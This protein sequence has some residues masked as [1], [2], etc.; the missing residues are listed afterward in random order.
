M[1]TARIVNEANNQEIHFAP[2]FLFGSQQSPS[3]RSFTS[4]SRHILPGYNSPGIL[5]TRDLTSS[6]NKNVHWSPV[7]VRERSPSKLADEKIK[8]TGSDINK[9]STL[10]S[11]GPPLRSLNDIIVVPPEKHPRLEPSERLNGTKKTV[12]LNHYEIQDNLLARTEL[13][14]LE[15]E[16]GEDDEIY[17]VTVFGFQSEQN[18][19]IL[20]LF[21]R[22]GDIMAQKIPKYGNW[23]HIRYSSPV[24]ARQALSKNAS[25]FK[26]LMIGVIPCKDRDALE[27]ESGQRTK[28]LFP[29][30]NSNQISD[31]SNKSSIL[32]G[33]K[34]LG[35]DDSSL[36]DGN[37]LVPS[38][39]ANKSN[40]SSLPSRARLSISSRAGMRPLNSSY[41][42]KDGDNNMDSS[43]QLLN[44]SGAGGDD[45]FMGK[46]WNIFT[47][48]GTGS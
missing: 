14:Q 24:H 28:P 38:T 30:S 12:P 26:G 10:L 36:F 15:E 19:E 1:D 17:W 20:E 45:S 43:F 25:I 47:T 21:S 33:S 44:R 9:S 39:S 48:T 29:Q 37:R 3:R 34:L 4:P 16:N 6:G 40:R 23:I 18:G 22:H 35:Q 42:S 32:N 27:D 41:T 5:K 31:E 8:R 13:V 7:L 46:L 2:S 11:N